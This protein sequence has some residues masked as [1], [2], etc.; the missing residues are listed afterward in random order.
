MTTSASRS[1]T[2]IKVRRVELELR[3]RDSVDRPGLQE[4]DVSEWEK[5]SRAI[6][7][8]PLVRLVNVLGVGVAHPVYACTCWLMA[9][10]VGNRAH[11][12]GGFSSG[13]EAS[14]NPKARCRLRGRNIRRTLT[15]ELDRLAPA[16]FAAWR[17]HA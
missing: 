11:T 17:I 14:R 10:D 6:R 9:H 15:A 13:V 12:I 16:H 1:A 4:N 7:A 3:P 8:E 2:V 5:G